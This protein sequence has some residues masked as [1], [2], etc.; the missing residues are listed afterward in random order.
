MFRAIVTLPAEHSH[1]PAAINTIASG[2]ESLR[3]ER[4]HHS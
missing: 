4:T 3:P 1:P 2:L